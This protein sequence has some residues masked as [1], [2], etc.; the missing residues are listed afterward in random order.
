[1]PLEPLWAAYEKRPDRAACPDYLVLPPVS[2]SY[3]ADLKAY[4]DAAPFYKAFQWR[5]GMP[6]KKYE[7]YLAVAGRRRVAFMV[8]ILEVC[9]RRLGYLRDPSA[10]VI[11]GEGKNGDWVYWN[12]HAFTWFAEQVDVPTS[13]DSRRRKR[14][15]DS[16]NDPPSYETFRRET[17]GIRTFHESLHFGEEGERA[18]QHFLVNQGW[19][20][21]R[22]YGEEKRG[23]YG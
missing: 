18:V 3:L 4:E 6:R 19:N 22:L 17:A 1:M 13:M 7:G 15:Y 21:Y 2:Q 23:R 16:A 14:P 12:Q 20:V 10:T 9:H 11:E 8:M 5:H